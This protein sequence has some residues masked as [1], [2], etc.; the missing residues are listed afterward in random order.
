MTSDEARFQ[1][2]RAAAGPPGAFTC[3]PAL[4]PVPVA[5]LLRPRSV[6]IIGISPEPGS[7]G[8]NV[9]T[10]LRSFGYRGDIHLVSRGRT[11]VLGRACVATIDDLPPDID[12][13]VLCVPRAAVAEAVA[14]CGRR[15]MGGAIVFASGFAETGEAGIAE[16]DALAASARRSG[17]ALLGPNCLGLVNQVE[18]VPL[19]MGLLAPANGRARRVGLVAQSG[20]MMSAIR[21][22]ARA[23]GV[24]F[25]HMISTGNEAVVGMEDFTAELIADEETRVIALFLEQIRRP[26][27]FLALAARAREAGKAIVMFHS[28]RSAAARAAARSHTGALAGDFR[29]MVALV[30]HQGIVRVDSFDELIDTMALLARYPQPPVGGVGV[31][32]NSGAFCGIAHDVAA[33]AELE[34]P[35]LS[36]S[37]SERLR[38][39]MPSFAAPDN[40]LDLGTQLMREPQLLGTAAQAMLE[41][42]KVGSVVVAVVLGTPQQALDKAQAVLPVLDDAAKPAAFAAIGGEAMLPADFLARIDAGTTVFFRSPERALRALA[43]LT[44]YGR[45]LRRQKVR[46]RVPDATAVAPPGTG[47]LPEYLA[48]PWL[49][50]AG[51]PVPRGSLAR[52]ASE[53]VEMSR[54]LGFPVVL[55]A[56]AKDLLH[57]SDIG[58]VILGVRDANGVREGWD[59]LQRALA[60]SRP[61]LRLDGVL[62]EQMVRPGIEMV[63]GA[64]NDRD[65]GAVVMVGLGGIWVEAL[66]DVRLLAPDATADEIIGEIARLRGARLLEGARGAQPA[67]VA[68]LADIVGKVGKLMRA[69]PELVEIDL[70]PV[71]VHGRGQ[72]AC[73]LDALVVVAP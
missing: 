2:G 72:G 43:H 71:V 55:K 42:D 61:A 73:A 59:D 4:E 56:Q 68:A 11:E 35:R 28:G 70:N 57:K 47:I 48:K 64:R 15:R 31:I 69:R 39:L 27:L 24:G 29:T 18:G 6:A 23:R 52:N 65:W 3:N 45:A 37:A 25:S 46:A 1:A 41:D 5:R 13:A 26:R 58:G 62:V 8:A 22:A 30:A 7:F 40:P 9:L 34:I 50:A 67:D 63:V 19:S 20:A 53:A 21:E 66:D 51:I 17:L 14:A 60:K 16:Q 44:T 54:M 33:A 36:A 32:T 12:V 10:S 49:A 38:A